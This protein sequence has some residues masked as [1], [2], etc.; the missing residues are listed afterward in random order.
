[1][2]K[3]PRSV[4]RAK[5]PNCQIRPRFEL[6][7][8]DPKTK[9]LDSLLCYAETLV[10][11]TLQKERSAERLV[12]AVQKLQLLANTEVDK[13]QV[14][15]VEASKHG[16][17]DTIACK[18]GCCHC[19]YRVPEASI[20]EMLVVWDHIRNNFSAEEREALRERVRTYVEETAS[21]R[22]TN[23]RQA[24]SACPLLVHSKCS[25]YNSRPFSCRGLNSTSVSA[26]EAIRAGKESPTQRPQWPDQDLIVTAFRMGIRLGVFFEALEPPA[27]DL[28]HALHVL[29]EHPEAEGRY[30]AGK[31]CFV[32][33]RSSTECEGFDGGQHFPLKTGLPTVRRAISNC[34]LEM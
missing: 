25:V 2:W 18:V 30:V 16:R 8:D 27:V 11:R 4:V 19:C 26:C 5:D 28:G 20:P 21:F 14:A 31:D 24:H 3:R 6:A 22:P 10:E 17:G 33:S 34:L 13:F 12:R 32:L 7:G 1:M 9:R 23:L 29:F 15:A